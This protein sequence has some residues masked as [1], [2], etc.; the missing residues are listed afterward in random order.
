MGNYSSWPYNGAIC[1]TAHSRRFG[2]G[3]TVSLS[4][5]PDLMQAANP[6]LVSRVV[7]AFDPEGLFS[8]GAR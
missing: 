3:P 4:R 1:W 5:G 2:D 8:P 6:V 7:E